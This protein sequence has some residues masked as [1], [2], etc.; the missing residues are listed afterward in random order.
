MRE[1]SGQGGGKVDSR[2]APLHV[3]VEGDRLGETGFE[4]E[5]GDPLASNQIFQE[6][7]AEG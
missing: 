5:G 4:G 3:C 2:G 7:D 1:A 6:L